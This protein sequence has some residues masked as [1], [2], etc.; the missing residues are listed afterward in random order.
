MWRDGGDSEGF[1][2]ETSDCETLNS[3][4][5]SSAAR[6]KTLQTLFVL[7]RA[8]CGEVAARPSWSHW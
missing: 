1:D 4:L 8:F 3:T 7:F 2:L 5:I 6:L